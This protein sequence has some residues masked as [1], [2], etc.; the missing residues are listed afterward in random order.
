M[1]KKYATQDDLEQLENRL[2]RLIDE[3][4]CKRLQESGEAQ[5]LDIP[6]MPPVEYGK[7]YRGE[8]LDI[9]AIVDRNLKIRLEEY[10]REHFAGNVSRSLDVI[11]WNFFDKPKLSFQEKENET[12]SLEPIE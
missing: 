8:K 11:L 3:K 5:D 12:I 6:P 2:I 10:A 4:F 9:R 1:A 7:K